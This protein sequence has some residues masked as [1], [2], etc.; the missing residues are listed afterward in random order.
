MWEPIVIVN[1]DLPQRCL[2]GVVC[3]RQGVLPMREQ[4][5]MLSSSEVTSVAGGGAHAQHLRASL[6]IKTTRDYDSDTACPQEC[7]FGP[8]PAG[9]GMTRVRVRG[10]LGKRLTA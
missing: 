7:P 4:R 6:S 8:F 9:L 3:L 1:C 5:P 10:N 2:E